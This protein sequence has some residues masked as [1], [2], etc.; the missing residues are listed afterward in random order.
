MIY[1]D[2]NNVFTAQ[3]I[4]T[5]PMN[6]LELADGN[7]LGVRPEK[8]RL[9][10]QPLGT[11]L[12]LRGRVEVREMLGSETQY[13][14]TL[15]DGRRLM[16]KSQDSDFA[17]G[18]AVCLG[19]EEAALYLFDHEGWRIRDLTAAVKSSMTRQIRGLCDAN[20]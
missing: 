2:P 16:V 4:G 14:V 7:K 13:K 6:I 5:P 10:A 17:M 11:P 3:F 12:T 8:L 15:R 20:Q 9:S 18:Q 1:N 19:A